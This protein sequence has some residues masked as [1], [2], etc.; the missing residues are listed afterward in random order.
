MSDPQDDLQAK[1][2]KAKKADDARKSESSELEE[3]KMQ[4][5]EMTETAKRAMADMQNIKRQAENERRQVIMMAN[6]NLA[7]QLLTPLDNL[8]RALEHTPEAAKEWAQGVNMCI[9]QIDNILKETGLEEIDSLNQV[10]N[11]DLHEAL[12]QGPGPQNTVIE[13]LEKGYKIGERVIRHAKVKVGNG[14]E[15]SQ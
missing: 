3:L 11:P 13:V 9:T 8:H 6:V 2:D 10:F 12:V 5:T 15:E 7:K 14:Q 4:L 1:I